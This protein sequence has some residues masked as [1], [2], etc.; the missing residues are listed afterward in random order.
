MT[1]SREGPPNLLL[2]WLTENP[3]LVVVAHPNPLGL[4][5]RRFVRMTRRHYVFDRPGQGE[6]VLPVTAE[7]VRTA[8]GFTTLGGKIV[9][10]RAGAAG[11]VYARVLP[12]DLFNEAKFLKCLGRLA[13]LVH[14]G[15]AGPLSCAAD[16]GPF[17][18]RQDPADGGLVARNV[19]FRVGAAPVPVKSV[20][21]SKAPYPL[22]FTA[23]DGGEADVFDHGGDLTAEFAAHLHHLSGGARVQTEGA[24]DHGHPRQHPHDPQERRPDEAGDAAGGAPDGQAEGRG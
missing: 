18:V 7:C 19:T 15:Q 20:Y 4:G 21:N 8:D 16:G 2:R 22:V 5:P 17:D 13:L 10:R 3:D 9:Y 12:R 24:G 6:S 23:A 14:D 1:L 11:E